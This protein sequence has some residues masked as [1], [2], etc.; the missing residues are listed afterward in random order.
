MV[1]HPDEATRGATL[2]RR[3][4]GT[5]VGLLVVAA[6]CA[7]AAPQP[8][9]AAQP[10]PAQQPAARPAEAPQEAAKRAAQQPAKPGADLRQISGTV[11]IDGSSTVFPISEAMAEEFQKATGGKVRVTVGISGTGGGFK[12]FCSNETDVSDASRPILQAEIDA[13]K[14]NGISYVELPVAFDGLSVVVSPRNTFVDCMKVSELKKMWEPAAQGKVTKWNQIRAEWPDRKF[15]LFGAGADSG[16]FDYF[17]DAINGKE[18]A[19]RGDFIASE[20]DNVL[21][22]GV[23]ND[24]DALGYFGYAYYV[25]NPGR[26][27][28]AKIDAEKGGGCV[29]PS[30][31]TIASGTY[32]PLSRPIFIYVKLSAL[33]R[34][35]VREFVRFYLNPQNAGTLIKQVGY[36]P[37]PE[38]LYQLGLRRLEAKQA[39]TVFAGKTTLGVKLDDLFVKTPS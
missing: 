28:L 7:P 16:T 24:A 26:L 23:A 6:A 2:S 17:T 38:R 20:D 8:S 34:P 35:E 9:T 18:K 11:K 13:C 37:F 32:Q 19:S 4:A 10:A 30:A 25:E 29:A 39:G 1:S 22:Q 36:I 15:N 14:K 31:E 33:E 5:L 12:K 21:V 27:K 3:V